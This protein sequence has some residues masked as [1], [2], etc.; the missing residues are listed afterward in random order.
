MRRAA[1]FLVLYLIALS[2]NLSAST[3]LNKWTAINIGLA[4]LKSKYPHEYQDL[5]I[6]YRPYV[7]K[8]EDGI[9][10]VDGTIGIFVLGGGAPTISIRDRDSKVLKVQFQ[11]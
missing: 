1:L 2:Q 11:K 3:R 6:K 4:A 9:W 7:A 10:H 5:I 8:F